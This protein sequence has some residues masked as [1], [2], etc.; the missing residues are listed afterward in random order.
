MLVLQAR[1]AGV[2]CVLLPDEN[3]K[4]FDDLQ[5]FITDGLEVHFV[6]QYEDVYNV[7]FATDGKNTS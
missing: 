3:K 1:R 2:N 7:V 4:D 6:K 5:K